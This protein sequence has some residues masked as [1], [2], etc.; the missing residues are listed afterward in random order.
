MWRMSSLFPLSNS[1][2][3]EELYMWEYAVWMC[4]SISPFVCSRLSMVS[5]VISLPSAV[6]YR[7][8]EHS[9]KMVPNSLASSSS[10]ISSGSLIPATYL[11]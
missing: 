11:K 10:A 8:C 6:A 9:W 4:W 1:R 2:E 3:M 7:D 5:A